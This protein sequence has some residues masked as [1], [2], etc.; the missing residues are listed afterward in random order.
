M[1]QVRYSGRM[2]PPGKVDIMD[3]PE[4]ASRPGQERVRGSGP[5]CPVVPAQRELVFLGRRGRLGAG[6]PG[7]GG[8]RTCAP[9]AVAAR[10]RLVQVP[11][12]SMVPSCGTY[13]VP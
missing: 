13:R 3:R 12:G 9:W 1:G 6:D 5:G 8:G 4:A 7:P 10:T 2:G 11:A